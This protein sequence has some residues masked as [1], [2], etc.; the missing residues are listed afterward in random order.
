MSWFGRL[1]TTASRWTDAGLDALLP[2][3]CAVCGR[4]PSPGDRAGRCVVCGACAAALGRDGPRCAACGAPAAGSDCRACRGR[5]RGWGGIVVLGGYADELR[6]AVL[7]AKRPAGERIAAALAALLV[8]RHR[9]A[10]AA[11]APDAVVPV[12]MHWLRRLARGTSAAD[13]IARGVAAGLRRPCRRL[14]RRGRA[15]TMQNRLPVAERRD[16]VRGAFRPR[17][18]L[19]GLRILIVDDVTTTGSTLEACAEAAISA[20][21]AAVYAAAVARAD[22]GGPGDA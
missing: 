6:D 14:L 3:R 9:D 22:A 2:P 13:E 7:R 15:T 10:L 20:G 16:N 1:R 11:W 12:P 4:E 18:R 17:G 5:G 19:A 8:E 21:A